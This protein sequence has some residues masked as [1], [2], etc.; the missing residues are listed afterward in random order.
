V[1]A[2]TSPTNTP[3]YDALSAKEQAWVEKCFAAGMNHTA[4]SRSLGYQAPEK[5]GLRMSKNVHVQAA[6]RERMAAFRIEA[7]E[8]LYRVDQRARASAEDLL[9][10][11]TEITRPKRLR[12]LTEALDELRAKMEFEDAFVT[13]SGADE[14]EVEKHEARMAEWKRDELRL[15]MRLEQDPGAVEAWTGPPEET[16]VAE[17]DLAKMRDAGKL[18]LVKSVTETK[19]GRKVELYDA[20]HADD[21]LAKHTGLVGPTGTKDDPLHHAVA[22]I[23]LRIVNAPRSLD[24]PDGGS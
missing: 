7:N 21:L 18:H 20:Q 2:D 23:E 9:T 3:A 13:R 24:A 12:P 14:K 6:I 19:D 1:S 22:P 4:A 17:F 16:V 8:V 11:R 5:H 15:V 10:F